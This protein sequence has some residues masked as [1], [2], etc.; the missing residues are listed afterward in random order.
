VCSRRNIPYLSA[1]MFLAVIFGVSKIAW[2]SYY[3]AIYRGQRIASARQFELKIIGIFS[4]TIIAI[5]FVMNSL[6]NP[7]TGNG[8]RVNYPNPVFAKIG[9]IPIWSR[10]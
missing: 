5:Q 6:I 2:L 4:R 1:T 10:N 8:E 7:Y 3:I 9:I